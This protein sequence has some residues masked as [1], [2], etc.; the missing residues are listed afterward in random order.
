GSD[1]ID[2][3]LDPPELGRVRISMHFERGDVVT[4]TV[5]SERSDTLDLLK[6]HQDELTR[7]LEKAGFARVN[8]QFSADGSGQNFARHNFETPADGLFRADPLEDV[9]VQYLSLRTDNRLD[10]LV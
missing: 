2:V 5:S 3:R 10:R 4:A 1:Q 7:E 8:L 6:R 9:R